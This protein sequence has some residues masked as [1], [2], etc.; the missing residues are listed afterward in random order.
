MVLLLMVHYLRSSI[1]SNADSDFLYKSISHVKELNEETFQ[2]HAKESETPFIVVF[3]APWCGHCRNYVSKYASLASEYSSL[4][5]SFFALNCDAFSSLCNRLKIEA[6]PTVQ[7]YRLT[8]AESHPLTFSS[9]ERKK[10]IALLDRERERERERSNKGKFLN[11]SHS[12]ESG[13]STPVSSSS[14][15]SLPLSLPN[16]NVQP[17]N[18]GGRERER[19]NISLAERER[20]RE[21]W[22]TRTVN[23]RG[24]EREREKVSP[25]D[26]LNDGLASLQ[27]M[28]E[29]EFLSDTSQEK[30]LL[31]VRFLF[32]LSH[33]LPSDR[34]EPYRELTHKIYVLLLEEKE[35]ERERGRGS[36][37][38]REWSELLASVSTLSHSSRDKSGNI[39]WRVCGYDEKDGEREREK[40]SG[41]RES[42]SGSERGVYLWLV[43]P[44]SLYDSGCGRK[45]QSDIIFP[46]SLSLFFLRILS[47]S[48]NRRERERKETR[49]RERD[50]G[51]VLQRERDIDHIANG[52]CK[53]LCGL[54][55]P[56]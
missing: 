32:L 24:R 33:L 21:K 45:K 12:V 37:I 38:E 36:G 7:A 48:K 28:L 51:E 27:Y 53:R 31:L 25:E 43:V 4:S 41:E 49:K 13:M 8:S 35:R 1:S 46:L 44:V 14:S 19:E 26:R 39:V 23:S 2:F 3:Y 16:Y 30:V 20:E 34:S 22:L 50:R 6:Y 17:V 40:W 18:S 52:E 15:L 54:I 55:L 9:G 47:F 42:E 11:L 10:L 56:M 5:L 29:N